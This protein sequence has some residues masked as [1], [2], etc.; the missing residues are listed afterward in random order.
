MTQPSMPR[1]TAHEARLLRRPQTEMRSIWHAGVLVI[2]LVFTGCA[3]SAAPAAAPTIVAPTAAV[4]A[5]AP[6]IGAS[7]ATA[8]PA[9]PTPAVPTPPAQVQAPTIVQVVTLDNLFQ[10]PYT[11]V[12][13]GTLVR[14]QNRGEDDHDA[15]ALDGSFESPVLK[16]GE[17]FEH[18]FPTPGTFPYVCSLHEDMAGTVVVQ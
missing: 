8:T 16:P 17:A 18:R 6:T 11:E 7:N 15:T 5:P 2:T 12:R 4:S 9:V 10:P 14:W 1:P 3:S 13:T